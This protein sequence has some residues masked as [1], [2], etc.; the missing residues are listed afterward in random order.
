MFV[1][2]GCAWQRRRMSWIQKTNP[3]V[4]DDSS[5]TPRGED[6]GDED[7]TRHGT[8]RLLLAATPVRKVRVGLYVGL[9]IGLERRHKGL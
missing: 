1:Q 4:S 3:L 2:G 8:H 7:E 6:E 5:P 9:Y